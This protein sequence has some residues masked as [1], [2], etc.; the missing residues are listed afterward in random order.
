MLLVTRQW[1]NQ[2]SIVANSKYIKYLHIHSILVA[3]SVIFGLFVD[4]SCLQWQALG[5]N[6]SMAEKTTLARKL[7]KEWILLSN[8]TFNWFEIIYY[9]NC[10]QG[11]TLA[12]ML[13]YN[14]DFA[15]PSVRCVFSKTFGRKLTISFFLDN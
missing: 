3:R 5:A 9:S 15:I 12:T 4:Q 10:C 11:D 6:L 8:I 2:Y 7:F 13:D 14:L 1:W